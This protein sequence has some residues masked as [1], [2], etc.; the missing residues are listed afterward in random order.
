M[1]STK[2][3]IKK[4]LTNAE[5]DAQYAKTLGL[6]VCAC[7]WYA[8]RDHVCWPKAQR[9]ADGMQKAFVFIPST[10]LGHGDHRL[11][12]KYTKDIQLTLEFDKSGSVR[13]ESLWWLNRVHEPQLTALVK[14]LFTAVSAGRR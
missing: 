9:A 8:G 1:N 3:R 12:F 10:R 2:P 7:G 4:V 11:T 5:R 14:G 13:V 6:T